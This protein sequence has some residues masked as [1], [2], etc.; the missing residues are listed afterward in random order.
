MH[1]N[2]YVYDPSLWKS[3][4][5]R[6]LGRALRVSVLRVFDGDDRLAGCLALGFVSSPASHSLSVRGGA[7][8]AH[9]PGPYLALSDYQCILTFPMTLGTTRTHYIVRCLHRRN[10]GDIGPAFPRS[11]KRDSTSTV[12]SESIDDFLNIKAKKLHDALKGRHKWAWRRYT[13][14]SHSG[15]FD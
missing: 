6:M 10:T 8:F 12:W 2:I 1:L 13:S 7:H 14:E 11:T 3:T 15:F 5:S 4:S 9:L